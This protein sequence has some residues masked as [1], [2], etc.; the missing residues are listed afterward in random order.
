MTVR[1]L[2]RAAVVDGAPPPYN[3]LHLKVFYPAHLSGDDR[4]QN[5]G[6]VSANAEQ[7]PF[8][9]VILFN[10]INCGPEVY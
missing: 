9:M 2:F 7:A 5:L 4:D 10:G 1:A 8:P 3:T 6:I